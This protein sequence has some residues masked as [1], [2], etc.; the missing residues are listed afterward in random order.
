MENL[1]D[2]STITENSSSLLIEIEEDEEVQIESNSRIG[3]PHHVKPLGINNKI[4]TLPFSLE[5]RRS[6]K[7]K[8]SHTHRKQYLSSW[9]DHPASFYLTYSYD[10]LGIKRSKTERWLQKKTDESTGI[11]TLGCYLCKEHNMIACKNGKE[12]TWATKGFSVLA[13]DKIK[14][15][16]L[17][18][19]HKKAE[20]LEIQITSKNQTDW[21]STRTAVLSGQEE[22]IHNLIYSSIYLCQ[23]DHSLNSFTPLC[24]LLEKVGVKLL[25]AEVSGV[26]YRNDS[27]ALTFLQHVASVLHDDLVK[28]LKESPVLGKYSEQT[29]YS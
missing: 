7:E 2:P 10:T 18:D 1:E 5:S 12:N 15:H 21:I 26:S 20:E 11:T 19:A 24:N 29:F 9:E 16:H 25:P 17:S 14:E 27:A 3:S 22:S 28:K 13:L 8:K 4:N 6:S 23:N